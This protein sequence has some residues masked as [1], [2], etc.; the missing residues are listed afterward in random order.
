MT[1]T[2]WMLLTVPLNTVNRKMS[3]A[4]LVLL[5]VKLRSPVTATGLL[6]IKALPC[7]N[8]SSVARSPSAL[9]RT[10]T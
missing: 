9:Q 8:R 10:V 6:S 7:A 5:T 1:E 4:P 2:V 3:V